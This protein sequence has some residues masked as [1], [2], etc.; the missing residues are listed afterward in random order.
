MNQRER[1]IRE[2][3]LA[4]EDHYKHGK[5]GS[6]RHRCAYLAIEQAFPGLAATILNPDGTKA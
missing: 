2:L 1:L 3:L 4:R 5:S 6:E